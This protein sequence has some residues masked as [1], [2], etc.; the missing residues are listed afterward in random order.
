MQERTRSSRKNWIPVWF[1]LYKEF[2]LPISI[3]ILRVNRFNDSSDYKLYDHS[4]ADG[5]SLGL[6]ILADDDWKIDL[7]D[8]KLKPMPPWWKKLISILKYPY[9]ARIQQVK[10]KQFDQDKKAEIGPYFFH[11]NREQSQKIHAHCT[12]KNINL[13]ALILWAA[14]S[15]VNKTLASSNNKKGIWWIPVDMRSMLPSTQTM[16]NLTSHIAVEIAPDAT[17][18][19]VKKSLSTKLRNRDFVG[20]WWWLQI[21]NIIGEK[22]MKKI[23]HDQIKR[24]RWTGTLTNMGSWP[25]PG[26]TPPTDFTYAVFGNPPAPIGHPVALGASVYFDEIYLCA[27]LNEC[28]LQNKDEAKNYFTQ[29]VKAILAESGVEAAS[30]SVSSPAP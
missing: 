22:G 8:L 17:T 10:W 4:E 29:L 14:N 13:N 21:G 18:A 1:K 11:F 26:F 9:W 12:Q 28:I 6:K 2:G 25:K 24:N 5:F 7:S 16:E 23:L 3:H 19:N 15:T 30:V 20:A 27:T